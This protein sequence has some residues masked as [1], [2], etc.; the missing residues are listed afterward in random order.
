MQSNS[1][2]TALRRK[3][4]VT[5]VDKWE[6]FVTLR[7]GTQQQQMSRPREIV[8]PQIRPRPSLLPTI[9]KVESIHNYIQEK[10]KKRTSGRCLNKLERALVGT[11]RP[12]PRH[13]DSLTKTISFFLSQL[14]MKAAQFSGRLEDIP[15]RSHRW[16]HSFIEDNFPRLATVS[17]M[18]RLRSS[19]VSFWNNQRQFRRAM[20]S[21]RW[22]R[23]PTIFIDQPLPLSLKYSIFVRRDAHSKAGEKK[24]S[25][26]AP[27][28]SANKHRTII[29]ISSDKSNE[30]GEHTYTLEG[31]S[32]IDQSKQES[33]SEMKV[34][35]GEFESSGEGVERREDKDNGSEELDNISLNNSLQAI[36]EA[37]FKSFKRRKP[38]SG[39]EDDS[40]DSSFSVDGGEMELRKGRKGRRLRPRL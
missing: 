14:E 20:M 17:S 10:P 21:G 37:T 6:E 3:T 19:L 16:I 23:F 12:S 36:D 29:T 28:H 38:R 35:M 5:Q 9:V 8:I 39:E 33:P 24:K 7:G 11:F 34:C 26:P 25:L 32:D 13:Q 30:T 15:N 2:E 31:S 27:R 4:L 1:E 18:I 22:N 40:G